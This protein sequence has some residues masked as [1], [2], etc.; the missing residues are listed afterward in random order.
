MIPLF[1][2]AGLPWRM[3]FARCFPITWAM[4]ESAALARHAHFLGNPHYRA[5]RAFYRGW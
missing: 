5:V 2:M 4:M 3:G 1:W